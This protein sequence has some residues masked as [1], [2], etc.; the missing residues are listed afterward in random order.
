[1]T[2]V[3]GVVGGGQL[4]LYF[5][6][7]AR[8]L[9]FR[10]VVLDPDPDSIAGRFADHHIVCPYDDPRGLE[11]MSS[12]CD[13]V[14]IEFENVPSSSL[15][16]LERTT[17]VRPSSEA[18]RIAAD[19]RLEKEFLGSIDCAVAPWAS[20]ANADDLM[21]L[22]GD[23]QWNAPMIVKT[24]RFGYDGHGQRR[25]QRAG[26]L[27]R[28]WDELG[29]QACVVERKLPLAE[30]LSVVIAR[31]VEGSTAVYPATRN[32]HVAGVLDVSVSPI[33]GAL[34][35]EAREITRRI[36]DA[37]GYVGVMGV[38]FFV[39]DGRLLVNEI[40]PRPHNSGHWTIDAAEASQFEQQVRCVAGLP[41]ADNAMTSGSVAMVNLLGDLWT[42][43]EP[44]WTV[45]D[46][47]DDAH[48]HLYGKSDPRP[49][50]KMGHIT[51][52]G[53]DPQKVESM[54]LNLRTT[55]TRTSSH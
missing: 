33:H 47:I 22:T 49:G 16:T 13:A 36:A 27:A 6:R 35:S 4:G 31:S 15:E 54:G 19:R 50:R 52:C 2:R 45:L 11:E 23:E 51:V 39:V 10:T 41:L 5:C 40:A 53:D 55:A 8:L 3:L 7:S 1:M 34:A 29:R 38:E 46:D 43:G 44:D 25:I 30:E 26:Q 14:T 32:V 21:S 9:G 18:V 42:H 37:L 28:A 24:S 20:L 48:L 17:I 12:R